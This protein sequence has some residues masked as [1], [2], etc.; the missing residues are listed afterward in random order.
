MRFSRV[1]F[2]VHAA[3]V[4]IT[5]TTNGQP[6]DNRNATYFDGNIRGRG[7]PPRLEDVFFKHEQQRDRSLQNSCNDCRSGTSAYSRSSSFDTREEIFDQLSPSEYR[8]V[9]DFATS[10]DADIADDTKEGI[11]SA[12]KALNRNYIVFIQLFPPPKEE[13]IAY[14]DR[15][16]DIAP[17][18]YAIVTVNRGRKRPRDVMQYKIGPIVDGEVDTRRIE[19][20][21]L[22][23]DNEIPWSMRGNYNSVTSLFDESVHDQAYKL[24]RAFEFTTGG[25]CIGGSE[26]DGDDKVKFIQFANLATTPTR[27]VTSVH[28][29]LRT[30]D[31]E[32]GPSCLLP[33]PI[34]F[35]VI[36]DPD[37]DPSRWET[38]NFQ[39]CYKGPYDSAE[40]LLD[41]IY[42]GEVVPCKMNVGNQEWTSIDPVKPLRA[43]AEIKEPTSFHSRG[44]RYIIDSAADDD[45][46]VLSEE[47]NVH[48]QSNSISNS[49]KQAQAEGKDTNPNRRLRV[50]DFVSSSTTKEEPSS[51][52][53]TKGPRNRN[54]RT[55]RGGGGN[56]TGHRVT[57]LGWSFHVSSDQMH[58]MVIRNLSFK[59]ERLAYELSFQEYFASYSAMGGPGQTV[60]FDTNWEVGEYS[61]LELG[62]DCPE[63]ATLLP[64]VQHDGDRAEVS[65]NL[66]CIFEKPTGEPL[67]RHEFSKRDRVEGIGRTVL[68]VRVVSVMGNYDYIPTL[69]LMADG[70]MKVD[71]EMGG[72]LQAGYSVDSTDDNPESPWFGTRLRDNMA[73]LLH[74]HII[75]MKADLDVG[76]VRNTLKAGKIKYGTYEEATGGKH[77]APLWH[78]SDGVKYM[79]WETI[80]DER[81]ISHTD[82][83]AIVI[84]SDTKNR[85]GSRRS[86]EIVFD[87]SI[88][89]QVFP[90]WHPLGA[91]TAWQYSNVAIT[92]QK[93]RE[94]YCSFPSNYQVGRAFPSFDLREFQKDQDPVVG[95]D[96]VFWIMFGLQHYPKAEDVP[97]VSNF[98]S[99]F[100][101]K[102]RN[103]YDRAAFE[104]LPDNRKQD[105][106]SCVP[107]FV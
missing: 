88:P 64:I 105:H 48:H 63:D 98:G 95:E 5:S 25:S 67:W 21:E 39:Y 75:G 80:G 65:K 92:R 87:H 22:L 1:I 83:D 40:A 104:D 4:S 24:R 89:R 55:V 18:R 27:R 76:G 20:D 3:S 53:K 31:G 66:M 74:D 7:G 10:D 58:G 38:T 14:L 28:F 91:A 43:D 15:R 49:G 45:R 51:G 54:L 2:L 19:V 60:Y 102:P 30:E 26:C 78:T 103:M 8:S 100:V 11:N 106:A 82:Y 86:Y 16:T 9:V 93:D 23:S 12:S 50:S 99:G 69:T 73:G 56:G 62:L 107:P 36:E 37:K 61:P 29:I 72:Y 77:P 47:R 32:F 46:R 57:W 71:V 59:G 42:S 96:L 70:V 17:K 44:K 35:Q 79:D 101:L 13:A 90:E 33:I 34:S 84:E 52:T 68:Q 6:F 85:W 81:G 41:A 94:R 97:L